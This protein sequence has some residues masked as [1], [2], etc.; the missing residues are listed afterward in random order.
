MAPK[1]GHCIVYSQVVLK[2]DFP[3]QIMFLNIL[4]GY[5]KFSVC[6]AKPYILRDIFKQVC[7]GT[8]VF[9]DKIQPC[10]RRLEVQLPPNKYIACGTAGLGG[11]LVSVGVNSINSKGI[12][13]TDT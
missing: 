7:S 5:T 6:A 3:P 10:V 1:K 12:Q 2:R 13:R 9:R 4:S 11:L 8:Q